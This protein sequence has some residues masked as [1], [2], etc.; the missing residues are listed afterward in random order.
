MYVLHGRH[1]VHDSDSRTLLWTP[2]EK[3]PERRR[4]GD[5][6]KDGN[7]SKKTTETVNLSPPEELRTVRPGR[8]LSGLITSK[9][10]VTRD[11][12]KYPLRAGEPPF[13]ALW[14]EVLLRKEGKPGSPEL[15]IYLPYTTNGGEGL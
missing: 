7:I 1:A 13:R 5:P 8:K 15:F 12:L 9:I 10:I 2:Y 11:S 3:R 4:I 14:L 6:S